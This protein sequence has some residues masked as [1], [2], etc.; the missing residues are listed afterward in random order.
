MTRAGAAGLV[1]PQH[2]A[3]PP[4][5]P[6]PTQDRYSPISYVLKTKSQL[7]LPSLFSALTFIRKV[8]CEKRKW[9]ALTRQK[10]CCVCPGAGGRRT[11]VLL[12]GLLWTDTGGQSSWTLTTYQHKDG[13]GAAE[14]PARA[15]LNTL[16]ESITD[17]GVRE[18]LFGLSLQ[19]HDMT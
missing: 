6:P 3:M 14:S 16:P 1:A 5:L 2:L 9:R 19:G 17:T 11:S 4:R 15:E 10:T 7:S 13:G 18:H 12:H 8:S